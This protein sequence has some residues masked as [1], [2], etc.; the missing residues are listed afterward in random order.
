MKS[1]ENVFTVFLPSHPILH[2]LKV[3]LTSDFESSEYRRP[4]EAEGK[5]E[6]VINME[7]GASEK[8]F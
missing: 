2:P 6:G 4:N 3:L 8:T 1:K 7:R 5:E